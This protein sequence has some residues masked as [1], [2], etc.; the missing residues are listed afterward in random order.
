[1]CQV[2]QAFIIGLVFPALLALW[3][4]VHPRSFG[5]ILEYG[6]EWIDWITGYGR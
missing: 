1:M 2:C 4:V 3:S 5:A 6:N